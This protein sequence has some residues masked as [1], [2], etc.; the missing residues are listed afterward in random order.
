MLSE[1]ASLR[2][3]VTASADRAA[4]VAEAETRVSA[5]HER[6]LVC[7]CLAWSRGSWGRP[8]SLSARR[9]AA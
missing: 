7:H 3:A 5:R 1:I 9:A 8:L 4:A 2:A 6:F